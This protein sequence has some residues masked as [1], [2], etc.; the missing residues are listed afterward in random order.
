ARVHL[1]HVVSATC[2]TIVAGGHPRQWFRRWRKLRDRGEREPR[3]GGGSEPLPR[4]R[5][6]GD[7]GQW[8]RRALGG[9]GRGFDRGELAGGGGGLGTVRHERHELRSVFDDGRGVAG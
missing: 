5:G 3:G 1:G 6:E 4:G 9:H 7:A 2:E 8:E